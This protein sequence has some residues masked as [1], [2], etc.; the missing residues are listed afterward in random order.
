MLSYII[1][2]PNPDFFHWEAVGLTVRWY[3]LLFASG[4]LISQQ[5]LFYIF[6]KEGKSE[7]FVEILTVYMIIATIIGARL[8]HV[9]FYEPDK[10]LKNPL[11]IL[12]IW[13]GGLASHGAA[14]GILV[15]LYLYANYPII[16]KLN[17][18]FPFLH[19]HAKKQKRE[20]QTY[21]WVV[22]RIVIV[23]AITGCLI[24]LGNF[25][26]SEI[27]GLPTGTNNGVIFA[28]SAEIMI[29]DSS[30]AVK[31]VEAS[32]GTDTGTGGDTRPVDLKITFLDNSYSEESL[33]SFLEKTVKGILTRYTYVTEHIQEPIDQ[34]LHYDLRQTPD[35]YQAVVNT[36]GI[37]RHPAQLYESISS[38]LLFFLLF[39]L[40]SRKKE[41]TPDGLLLGLFLVILWS[42]RFFYEFLKEPQVAFEQ[43]LILNMGQSLSIPLVLLGFYLVWRAY[44]TDQGTGS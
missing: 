3:G 22:D 28:H 8:G 20:G 18:K 15:A 42:L 1:W 2:S 9:L 14:I 13:E 4:F 34:P 44:R 29:M 36:Q 12:K 30:P 5:I 38:L 39:Y 31:E 26:N 23:V 6:R 24:R 27:V 16:I 19:Y 35:G 33:R 7:K 21:L 32:K 10:Y 17:W 40:W 41:N 11:D 37:V 25:I 43:D